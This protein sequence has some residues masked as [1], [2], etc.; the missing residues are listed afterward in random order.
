MCLSQC[1]D[2]CLVFFFPKMLVNDI[3]LLTKGIA[4]F[5]FL[6]DN[7]VLFVEKLNEMKTACSD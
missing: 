5:Q 4:T 6:G 3:S 7:F 2:S 1:H